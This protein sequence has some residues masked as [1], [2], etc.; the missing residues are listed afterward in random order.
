MS[1]S[2]QVSQQKL[3]DLA[4]HFHPQKLHFQQSDSS[5]NLWVRDDTPYY[6]MDTGQTWRL[7]KMIEGEAKPKKELL[8]SGINRRIIEELLDEMDFQFE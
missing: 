4:N 1:N 3:E 7:F 2:K 6:F 8:K 5:E